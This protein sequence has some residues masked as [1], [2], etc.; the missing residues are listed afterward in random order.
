MAHFIESTG[1]LI[2]VLFIAMMVFAGAATVVGLVA[3]E[4]DVLFASLFGLASQFSGA[5][6]L[7]IKQKGSPS[8]DATGRNVEVNVA[9]PE[10]ET[11]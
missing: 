7:L 4:R 6:L 5:L 8:V 2:A 9:S 1:G 10:S 3:P 11:K